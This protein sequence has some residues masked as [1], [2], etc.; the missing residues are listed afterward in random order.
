MVA[1]DVS[2]KHEGPIPK[3]EKRK[4][5]RP[6]RIFTV[7]DQEWLTFRAEWLEANPPD[8]GEEYYQ[9]A[10]CPYPVHKDEV[11][12]DHIIPR[13]RRKDLKYDP[14]N[15]QPAHAICNTL[16]GSKV[17]KENNDV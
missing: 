13:S 1:S 17:I 8:L 12:L 5:K 16:K 15:I 6:K 14:L 7:V 11:T 2:P 3:P 9:C 10:L 4:K